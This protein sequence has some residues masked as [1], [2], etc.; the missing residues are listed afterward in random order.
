MPG[1]NNSITITEVATKAAV[2]VGTVSKVLNGGNCKPEIHDRVESAIRELNYQPNPYAQAVRSMKINC[3]GIIVEARCR[4]NNLWMHDLLL[5]LFEEVSQSKYFTHV[6]YVD[7]TA[8]KFDFNGMAKRVNGIILIGTF[9]APFYEAYN[10][11]FD[12]PTI[13]YWNECPAR[14]GILVKV[15]FSNAIRQLFEHFLALGHTRIAMIS[16][17][18]PSDLDKADCWAA[19]ADE[20]LPNYDRGRIRIAASGN[21][22]SQLGYE[23]T[24][25]LLE[26]YP[27]TTAIFYAADNLAIGGISYLRQRKL[28]FPEDL[29]L[30][31]FDNTVWA[32]NVIPALTGIG[33][34]FT[35]LA[36][37]LCLTLIGR[38]EGTDTGSAPVVQMRL[39]R[40]G[41]SARISERQQSITPKTRKRT[42]HEKDKEIHID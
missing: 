15:E 28:R 36:C 14:N 10:R 5:A 2:S 18:N 38:I 39:E 19:I 42:D 17:N 24:R 11:Q 7:S 35:E 9:E 27:D 23:S 6:M 16:A 37:K 13:Y 30:A 4:E 12:V 29:S 8:G 25:E 21:D 20:L 41:S 22:T 31:G 1:T 40:C 3:I 32:K 33:F 34:D 26:R